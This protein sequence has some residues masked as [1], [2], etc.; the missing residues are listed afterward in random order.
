M[1]KPGSRVMNFLGF[2]KGKKKPAAETTSEQSAQSDAA[3]D[4]D[5]EEDDEEED[6]EED[7]RP[8][9]SEDEGEGERE[10]ALAAARTEAT[11]AERRRVGA[12]VSGVDP[13]QAQFALHLAL[14]TDMTVEQAQAAIAAAPKGGKGAPFI[15][16]MAAV[17]GQVRQPGFG[18]SSPG[19]EAS[20]SGRMSAD[21]KKRGWI[22]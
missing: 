3:R 20:L 15:A 14:N 16:A 2:G 6:E 7:D 11:A 21:L 5:E 9:A 17:S 22:K 12:I 13:A 10:A 19:K 1:S 8:E 18:A 4:D